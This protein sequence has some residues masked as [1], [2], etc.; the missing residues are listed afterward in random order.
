MAMPIG[1]AQSI[2]SHGIKKGVNRLL[3]GITMKL[4]RIFKEH[5]VTIAIILSIVVTA[6]LSF[7]DRIPDEDVIG[8][9]LCADVGLAISMFYSSLKSEDSFYEVMRCLNPQATS[10]IVT[11]K[12]HYK[13]LDAAVIKAES[14]ICIMTIDTAL[15][16]GIVS[17]V[18]E[19]EVYYNDIETIAKTKREITIRRIYGLPTDEAARK[20]KIEWI[21]S[22]LIKYKDCPNYHMVIFDW[23]KFSSVSNLF[24]IQIVDESFVGLVNMVYAS[25]GVIGGGED[26][27]IKDQNV[28]RHFKLYY[29]A[30]WEQCDKLKIGG[31]IMANLD[32]FK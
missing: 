29:E 15:R 18:P 22:D 32:N 5:Y 1:K 19:R 31:S 24:S 2:I 23:R 12:E 4:P 26:I 7:A 20:D 14:E 16:A 8:Y 9:L 30:V 28:V 13:L 27:C 11:R 21:R 25:I 3:E 10:N 6:A 17:T